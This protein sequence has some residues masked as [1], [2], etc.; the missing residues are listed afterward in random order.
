MHEEVGD[1]SYVRA[2][3]AVM[4]K[5][6]AL[7]R[8]KLICPLVLP[9]KMYPWGLVRPKVAALPRLKPILPPG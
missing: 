7:P 1:S 3:G 4:L 6:A 5:V 2:W 9:S 8:R